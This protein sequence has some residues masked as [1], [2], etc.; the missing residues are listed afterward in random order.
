LKKLLIFV[1][2][3][4]CGS[5]PAMAQGQFISGAITAADSGTECATAGGFVSIPTATSASVSF[6]VSN[7]FSATLQ[8]VT[9]VDGTNYTTATAYPPN[10]TTGVTITTSGGTWTVAVPAMATFCVRASA[11]ASGTATV[12]MRN[13]TAVS[14]SSLTSGGGGGGGAVSSVFTRTGAVAATTGDYTCTQVTGCPASSDVFVATTS[15]AGISAAT[16]VQ[17]VDDD[18]TN[19]CGAATTAWVTAINAYAGKGAASV[20]ILGS[21]NGKAFLLSTC[22]IIFTNIRGV[23]ISG[24][25]TIDC[26]MAL[27]SCFQIGPTVATGTAF[28]AGQQPPVYRI[29]YLTFIG[30]QSLTGTGGNGSGQGGGIYVMPT[31][32]AVYITDDNFTGSGTIGSGLNTGFGAITTNGACTNYSIYF[33]TPFP[34]GFVNRVNIQVNSSGVVTAGGCG[35]GNPSGSA[36]GTNTVMI[37]NSAIYTG[38]EASGTGQCGSIG[39]NDGGSYGTL[40][41]NNVFGFGIPILLQGIG[42]KLIGNQLDS[43]QCA[44]GGVSSTI[45]LGGGIGVGPAVITDNTI[46]GGVTGHSTYFTAP[47]ATNAGTYAGWDITNNID[48]SLSNTVQMFPSS[49][50]C[51]PLGF[52]PCIMS[53]NEYIPEPAG[54]GSTGT[55]WKVWTMIAAC[56]PGPLTA[57]ETAQ[58]LLTTGGPAYDVTC[59]IEMSTAATTSSTLP[60]CVV[61]YTDEFSGA[62]VNVTVTPT[63]AAGVV[64]CSGTTANTLGNACQGTIAVANTNGSALTFSTVNYASVGATPMAYY[65]NAYVKLAN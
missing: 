52:R 15:C 61:S 29:S 20:Q 48:T 8:F 34:T 43:T 2:L 64:G 38:G 22:N 3:V 24:P 32:S 4:L 40:S 35:I 10:S 55:G 47:A 50:N 36:A 1:F 41:D 5:V 16:C 54:C 25:A 65:I 63:W 12:N 9:T 57:N 17:W 58:T 60:Q 13:S 18:S 30:G 53:G 62:A 11:Y 39:I 27:Q 46:Q 44:A 51:A 26:A 33:D 6:S 37:S 49:T 31:G 42:H 28:V 14:V 59:Q 7:T 19:N 21:G 23:T 45:Q 56:Q